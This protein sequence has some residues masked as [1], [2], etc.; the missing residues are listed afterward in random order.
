[1]TDKLSKPI[2]PENCT[3]MHQTRHYIGIKCYVPDQLRDKSNIYLMQ[4]YDAS[5]RLLIGTATSQNPEDISIGN[6]PQEYEDL[7]LFIRTMDARS[8]T[9]DANI[10]YAPTVAKIRTGGKIKIRINHF[11]Y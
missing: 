5:T 9:S 4:V 7:L 2:P 1:M 10:I 11:I 8:I 3:I 6:L